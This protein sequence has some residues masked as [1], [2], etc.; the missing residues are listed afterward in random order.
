MGGADVAGQERGSTLPL[1][2]IYSMIALALLL[3]VTAAS[4]LYLERKRLLTLADGAALVGAESFDL[5]AVTVTD[6]SVRPRLTD[7]RVRSAVE[8]YL[9]HLPS[10]FDSLRLEEAAAP[11]SRTALVGLSAVWRPPVISAFV[12]EGIRIEVTAEARLVL[13]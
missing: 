1:V 2:V 7:Q 8:E 12:P 6:D 13:D 4:S 5:A 10:R 11:D 9:R 3:V